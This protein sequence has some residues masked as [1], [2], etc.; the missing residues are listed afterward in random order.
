MEESRMWNTN[1][2]NEI[3]QYSFNKNSKGM[4]STP[5]E[6]KDVNNYSQEKGVSLFISQNGIDML[7]EELEASKEA[8]DTTPD[9]AKI[10]EIARRISNGDKVPVS[11]E[12]KLMEYSSEMYQMAKAA[13]VVN[14]NKKHKEYQSLFKDENEIDMDEKLRDLEG[15]EIKEE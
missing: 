5:K 2:K 12:K 8:E 9:L 4:A 7:Q 11:D 6:I 15:E 10:L 13:A 1:L 14:A 3:Y